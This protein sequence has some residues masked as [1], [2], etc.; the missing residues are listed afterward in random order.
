LKLTGNSF[1]RM[2]IWEQKLYPF[3]SGIGSGGEAIEEG[4]F[5][6]HHRQVCGEFWHFSISLANL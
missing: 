6:K 2:L 5:G 1:G 3:E 4:D